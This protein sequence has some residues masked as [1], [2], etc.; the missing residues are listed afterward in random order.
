MHTT[1]PA[2]DP[3]QVELDR[4]QDPL[5]LLLHLRSAASAPV[6]C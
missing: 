1:E 2:M 5:D 6:V 3:F 4:F